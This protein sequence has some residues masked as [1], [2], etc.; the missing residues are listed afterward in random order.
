VNASNG[1]ACAAEITNTTFRRSLSEHEAGSI[2]VMRP[3]RRKIRMFQTLCNAG[4]A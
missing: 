2:L 4:T 1:Q 3:A